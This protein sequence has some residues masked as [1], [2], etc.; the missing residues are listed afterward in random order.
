MP[1]RT[2][3]AKVPI[4]FVIVTLDSHLATAAHDAAAKLREFA[5]GLELSLH[6]AA[7]WN[8]PDA[9]AR[10]RED[11]ARGHI[12]VVTQLFM[13]EH[14]SPVIDVL[15]ARR[16]QCDAIVG[17]MSAAQVVKLTRLGQFRMGAKQ[18]GPMA[19][20]KRLRGKNDK[21]GAAGARQMTMLRRLPKILR[22][23]PGAAQDLRAYFLT[24]QYWLAG[25][26]DNM[27][28]L[29]SF[30]IS[31]YANKERVQLRD[32]M[33]ELPPVEYPEVGYYHPKYGLTSQLKSKRSREGAVG[34]I[35]MRSYLLA[36]NTEHY[37]GVIR[38]LEARGLQVITVF[39]SGLDA[40]PAI[41]K[42]LIVNGDCRVDA[43]VSLTGFPLV[44]GPAYNDTAAAQQVLERLDVPFIAAHPL[45]FQT[46]EEWNQSSQGLT[47][48]EA[49]MMVALPELDGATG[50]LVFGGR[51]DESSEGPAWD[52]HSLPERAEVLAAR[53][54]KLIA[55]R[56]KE[57]NQRKIAIVLFNFPP[58]GGSTGTAAHLA[59]FES[60]YNLLQRL[61]AQGYR[62]DK[63]GSV[64]ELRQRILGG[65][66]S[67]FGTD[68][69]VH[70]RIS[71]D[72][73]VA[74]ERWLDE[75]EAA[76]GPAPGQDLTDG[77]HLLVLGADFGDVFVGVQPGFGY[78]GDPMRLLFEGSFAPTHAF[79]AFYRYLREDFCADAVLH[80]G[81]HGAL[82]F[83]PGKQVGMSES[84]WPDR[85][86]GDLPNIY[87]YAANN[88]SEGTLAKRRS[89]ATLI[90]YLTPSVTQAGVYKELQA[91]KSSV[92]RWRSLAPN[93]DEDERQNLATLIE[94]QA[95][96]L[97]LAPAAED[98]SDRAERMAHIRKAL[99]EY[100]TAL[101]P[102]GLHVLGES[103][104]QEERVD[105][106]GAMAQ[107][108]GV[109]LPRDVV[110]DI[111]DDASLAAVESAVKTEQG[112]AA[113]GRL[114]QTNAQLQEDHE[115]PAL[116][117]ALDGRFI[118]PV[119][120]GDLLQNPD[121]LPTGRNLHGFDPFKLPSRYA[122]LQGKQSA[123][124]LI[125]RHVAE[126][127]SLPES[128]AMVLWGT[129]NLKSEG[130]PLAQALALIGARPLFDGYGK[131][132]GAELVPL[133]E[134]GRPRIDVVMTLSGI[135]RDLLPLQT[136]LLADACY[137]AASADEPLEQNF[138][139][140]HT[141]AYQEAHDCELE[142]AALRVFGNAEGAYGANVNHLIEDGAW[143]EGDELGDAFTTRKCFAYGRAG[144]PVRH[145][146]LMHSVLGDVQLAFQNLESVEMGVTTLDHYFDG[147]GGINRA[148]N[149]ARGEMIPVY[150]SDQTV[151]EGK[152]RTLTEQVALETRTRM[153][154]PKWYES[155]LQHGYE[156]VR[157]IES[158]VTNTLG[159]S[160]TTGQVSP[161]VY[162][163]ITE[164][165]IL[166]EEMRTRLSEL[167][168][169]ASAKV[170]NRL[171]EAHERDY[172]VPD[173]ETLE[174]LKDASAE[175][176]DRMEGIVRGAVA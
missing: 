57:R 15:K 85:L 42:G 131:L 6:A 54:H 163:S 23:I 22:F 69:N 97:E 46:L 30:L 1:K 98:A 147:L 44:G 91:L 153:L 14:I 56:L 86:I 39:A 160:A 144:A 152:V 67:R 25:S 32:A 170:A 119:P 155:M 4:R 11:I 93:A 165:Y 124:K 121:V 141:L 171:L 156:G 159:W 88:P 120:G 110:V 123:D 176:E 167:N 111:A 161:W 154:N 73:H 127:F 175:L 13:D 35:V 28:G 138:V 17:C 81:T 142:T 45:E 80:F 34:L 66:S 5:P 139:R 148:V 129:D 157:Q 16:E 26:E 150:I 7:E 43:L 8:D 29:V 174:A 117:R 63:P 149:K 101:I 133:D 62:V 21:P 2:S 162:Q 126:G 128:L 164:T 173:E 40:R 3:R 109:V 84:C 113:C 158:H 107:A 61:S 168:P 95:G 41:E 9:L 19:L 10:C 33:P 59:V 105:L 169:T 96:E 64:D 87:L 99:H 60:L 50:T 114:V 94:T 143:E 112:R 92:E 70:A 68:A 36:G 72:D 55:L 166:D 100:E 136:K 12:I 151:G 122:L 31:R 134:L 106:L 103:P 130:A 90:S 47:P 48:I 71:T 118:A 172:W 102:H 89:S 79:A 140:K 27:Q 116:V 125:A 132:S 146:D 58:N 104:K 82:E 24:L 20:I 75:I 37:D 74:N 137:L 135:F 38:A 83:M 49:T 115:L 78:E 77:S 108:D 53:V 76:W 51:S 18:G 52:M 145:P 65:N